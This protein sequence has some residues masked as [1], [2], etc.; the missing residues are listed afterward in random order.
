MRASHIS[1]LSISIAINV[2]LIV[3]VAFLSNPS[4]SGGTPVGKKEAVARLAVARTNFLA[5]D[6]DWSR[7]ESTDY[8]TDIA[9]LRAVNC[10]EETIRDIILSEVG[11]L[12]SRKLAAAEPPPQN[13]WERPRFWSPG[14][15]AR[16]REFVN[17][18][19]DLIK[20]LLGFD[21]EEEQRKKVSASQ[22]RDSRYAFLPEAKAQQL[23]DL[24]NKYFLKETA[25]NA[26]AKG[27]FTPE[28]RAALNALANQ[29]R[30]E[31][32]ALLTSGEQF[33]YAVRNSALAQSL[34]QDLVAFAPNES[35]FR[36]IYKAD[37]SR[38]QLREQ[39][40][41]SPASEVDELVD[42]QLKDALGDERY[43]EYLWSKD[44][45]YKFL[46]KI[47]DRYNLP[48][49]TAAQVM[50]IHQWAEQRKLEF[51]NGPEFSVAQKAEAIDTIRSQTE[52]QLLDLL[53]EQAFTHYRQNSPVSLARAST[54]KAT[55]P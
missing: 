35:E 43:T 55:L 22:I 2:A 8:R 41:A 47:V 4:K 33:E 23:R 24:E 6:F 52:A 16:Q 31:L 42:N 1:M 45:G 37:V 51:A 7:I 29:K 5:P 39:N 49:Q 28:D 50:Q 36:A 9:N 40:P 20:E 17:E 38:Q 13:Y 48:Q 15:H 30:V 44:P 19:N 53:G 3:A 26:N 46:A 34:Q 25:I 12:Y 11:K 27:V 54:P 14:I 32:A 21:P 10:P 18:K